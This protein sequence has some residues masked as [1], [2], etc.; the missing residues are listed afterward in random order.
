MQTEWMAA[1]TGLEAY[2]RVRIAVARLGSARAFGVLN[3]RMSAPPEKAP[4]APVITIAETAGSASARRT[5][6]TMPVR[7]AWPSPFTGGLARVM[8]AMPSRVE[9]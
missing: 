4:P 7:S 5:A 2:S 8:I 9:Y 6:S 1:T 3:S